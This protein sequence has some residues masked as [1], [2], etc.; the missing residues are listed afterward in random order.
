MT[1]GHSKGPGVSAT[2]NT[3]SGAAG[4]IVKSGRVFSLDDEIQAA[5]A[6]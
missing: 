4:F 1:S 3:E 5:L 2:T 6:A